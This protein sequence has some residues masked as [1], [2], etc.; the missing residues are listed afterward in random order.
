MKQNVG[1]KLESL[2]DSD[3]AFRRISSESFGSTLKVLKSDVSSVCC[4]FEP[5]DRRF[6]E[7]LI[8]LE[9]IA[10]SKISLEDLHSFEKF[11]SSKGW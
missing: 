9:N 10:A 1:L 11:F 7:A 6:W 5:K 3:S 4:E 8:S 2:I